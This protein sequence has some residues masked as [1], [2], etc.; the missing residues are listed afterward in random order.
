MNFSQ[1]K[2]AILSLQYY[3]FPDATG[4]A[5]NLTHEINKRLVEGG[6]RVVIITCKPDDKYPDNEIIDGVEF[7]RISVASSKNPIKLWQA[8]RKKVRQYLIDEE[9]WI[10]HIHNPL[11]GVLALTLAS[12][13]IIPK[14]Y[15]FHSSWYDEEKI[16]LTESKQSKLNICYKLN[17]IRLMEWTCYWSSKTVLFLSNYT[18]QR[19][20]DY[21][22]FSKPRMRIIP[23]GVDTNKFIPLENDIES[24]ILRKRLGIP[25]DHKILLTVRRLEIRMGLDNLITAVGEIIHRSP[26]LKFKLL[27]VGKGSLNEKLKSLVAMSGLE[28]YVYFIGFVPNDLL[29]LYYGAADL[30]IMPS[31]FIEGFGLSTVESLS[32]GTPVLGTPIGGTPEILNPIDPNLVFLSSTPKSMANKIESFLKN[33]KPI[34][35]LKLKCRENAVSNYDWDFAV[36]KI[37]EEFELMWKNQ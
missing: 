2:P 11:I 30:F 4:G 7:D 26:E 13:R 16:N 28:N 12:Y 25:M 29:Q 8:V 14:I 3:S 1:S 33:P 37:E 24:N 32:T 21:Y 6:R 10:A 17:T 9:A 18:R 20:I 15:H 5:W 35:A 34:L 31:A 27:I 22:P 23:G 36:D 19:F